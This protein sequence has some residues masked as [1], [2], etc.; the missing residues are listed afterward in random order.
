[1]KRYLRESLSNFTV[2]DYMTIDTDALLS[3]VYEE[4]KQRNPTVFNVEDYRIT[5]GIVYIKANGTIFNFSINH[6]NKRKPPYVIL[7]K[8]EYRNSFE[9]SNDT[10]VSDIADQILYRIGNILGDE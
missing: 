8:N 5:H 7:R 3:D 4:V 2:S 9:L 10:T 1:M 6:D